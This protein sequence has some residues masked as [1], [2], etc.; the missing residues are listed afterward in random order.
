MYIYIYAHKLV[1]KV[2]VILNHYIY[3]CFASALNK[4]M[5]SNL[6]N[7]HANKKNLFIHKTMPVM[8]IIMTMYESDNDNKYDI[9]DHHHHQ[10]I[11]II[12]FFTSNRE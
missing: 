8:L 10:I 12:V 4:Y 7:N 9:D 3:T 2:T 11:T 6:D 5:N 1:A